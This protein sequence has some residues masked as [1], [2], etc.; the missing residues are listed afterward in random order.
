MYQESYSY[1]KNKNIK[2]EDFC[3]MIKIEQRFEIVNKVTFD[4]REIKILH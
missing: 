4:S 3:E 1:Y 2:I